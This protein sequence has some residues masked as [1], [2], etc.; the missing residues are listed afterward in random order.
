MKTIYYYNSTEKRTREN[1]PERRGNGEFR[2]KKEGLLGHEEIN[3]FLSCLRGVV[4]LQRWQITSLTPL[5]LWTP[6]MKGDTERVILMNTTT[7][8]TRMLLCSTSGRLGIKADLYKKK[9][10]SQSSQS[11]SKSV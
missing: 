5:V 3:A 6:E 10:F 7:H 9:R 2:F 4:I 11:V 8:R 1:D